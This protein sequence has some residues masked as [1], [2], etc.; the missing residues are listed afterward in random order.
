MASTFDSHAIAG[1]TTADL[2]DFEF[3]EPETQT[4]DVELSKFVAAV[5]RMVEVSRQAWSINDE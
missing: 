2:E 3:G 5:K 4:D 1:S